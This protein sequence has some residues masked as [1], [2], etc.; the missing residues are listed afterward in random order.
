MLNLIQIEIYKVFRKWRTYIG[1]GTIAIIVSII[2]IALLVEGRDYLEFLTR[3][4]S[5]TFVF[6][7]NFLNGYLISHIVLGSL[8]IHIPFLIALVAG[9]LLA[10]EATSGTYRM[11]ITR[12]VSRNQILFAKLIA[13]IVYTNLLVLFLAIMSL[14]LGIVLFGTGELIVIRNDMTIFATDDILWRF[15]LAYGLAAVSMSV[16]TALAFFFSS[17]VENAIGPIVATMAVIIVFLIM[18]NLDIEFFQNIKPYLFTSYTNSW[19]AVFEKPVEFEEIKTALIVL[20]IY[21]IALVSAT[22]FI[23]RKKDIVS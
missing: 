19:R 11:L 21:F 1:F 9:E 14:G 17:L 2:E 18:T 15:M 6:V 16:V 12:P 10:G 13:G 4:M 23:F 7:G 5:N 20:G 3:S 8:T 22:W